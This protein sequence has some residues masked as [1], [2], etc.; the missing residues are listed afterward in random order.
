GGRGRGPR[1]ALN[2]LRQLARL[3]LP[4]AIA[5]AGIAL[6]GLVD[7]AVVGRLGAAPLGAI[8]LGN[9]LFFGLAIVGMGAMMGLDPLFAQ[10]FGASDHRRARE[11]VWQG[12]WLSLLV[13]VVLAVPIAFL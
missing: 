3:A 1:G 9:G 10:A 6:M 2:E 8:G 11:L 4:I 13:T 7:T 12:M 5:Q